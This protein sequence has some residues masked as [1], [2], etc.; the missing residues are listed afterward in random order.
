MPSGTALKKVA[1]MFTF[2]RHVSIIGIVYKKSIYKK[3]SK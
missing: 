3:Y 2:Q 1:K